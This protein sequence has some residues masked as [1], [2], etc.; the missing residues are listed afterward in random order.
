MGGGVRLGI[1]DLRAGW[2]A[3]TLAAICRVLDATP[4]AILA[5]APAD[6]A[7]PADDIDPT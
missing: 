2:I 6:D 1:G 4:G 3:I 5:Y 7:D